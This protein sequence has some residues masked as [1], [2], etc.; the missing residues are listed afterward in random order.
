MDPSKSTAVNDCV[1]RQRV[2]STISRIVNVR[3]GD[4]GE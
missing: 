1:V 3:G 4:T 2:K